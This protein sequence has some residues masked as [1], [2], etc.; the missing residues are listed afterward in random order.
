MLK[1]SFLIKEE[2]DDI[3]N[4]NLVDASLRVDEVLDELDEI[5]AVLDVPSKV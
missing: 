4:W 3:L 5:P 1:T 2:L